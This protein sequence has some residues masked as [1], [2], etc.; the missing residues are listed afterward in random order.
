MLLKRNIQV[1]AA[2]EIGNEYFGNCINKNSGGNNNIQQHQM[3]Q[4]QC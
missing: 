1:F 3:K 2:S 4:Q